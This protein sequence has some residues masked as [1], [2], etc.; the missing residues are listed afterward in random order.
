MPFRHI[1]PSARQALAVAGRILTELGR[2][3]RVF[4][5]WVLFPA[6]MLILFG[7]VRADR[8]GLPEAFSATAPGIL[9]GAGLFFSCLGGPVSLLI[10]ERER[11][12]L[13]RLLAS[14]LDGRDYLLGVLGAYLVV[15]AAQVLLVYGLTVAVGG[16]FAGSI[17]LG[18]VIVF[19]SVL[20][21]VG[22][23]FVIAGGVVRTAEDAN[24][25]VAGVG[26]P[27]LVLGGTFFDADGLPTLLRTAAWANPIYHMNRTFRSV[28]HGGA[29]LQQ[30]GVNLVS[31]LVL[32][33]AAMILGIRSYRRVLDVERNV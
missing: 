28:A 16:R 5:L 25:A 29:D 10:A 24:G 12:T 6:A 26:V 17:L 1:V 22:I 7:W 33:A 11:R 14:P 4:A 9:I 19:L 27:L 31:L 2:S 20:A 18:V 23:G 21:Y 32:A 15:A 13:R 8:M 30:I 3:R